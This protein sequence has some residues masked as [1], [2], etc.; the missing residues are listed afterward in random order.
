MWV[1]T[2]SVDGKRLVSGSGDHT[3]KLWDLGGNKEGTCLRTYSDHYGY[4]I[5]DVCN[6]GIKMVSGDW[7]GQVRIW[8]FAGLKW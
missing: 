7:R 6:D 8:N 1:Q 2:I 3:I 4:P 5:G